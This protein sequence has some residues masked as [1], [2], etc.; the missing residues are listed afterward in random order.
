MGSAPVGTARLDR[1]HQRVIFRRD[2]VK[3]DRTAM[4]QTR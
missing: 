1:Y 4:S 3:D 2:V